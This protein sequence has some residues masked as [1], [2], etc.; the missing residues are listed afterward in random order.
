MSAQDSSFVRHAGLILFFLGFSFEFRVSVDASVNVGGVTPSRAPAASGDTSGFCCDSL[1][2]PSA[3]DVSYPGGGF[4]ALRSSLGI[5]S[6]PPF[7]I[8]PPCLVASYRSVSDEIAAGDGPKFFH[9]S[10]LDHSIWGTRET[11]S[12]RVSGVLHI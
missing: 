2:L 3:L 6:M 11:V 8:L 1:Y 7:P 10:K 5:R 12:G 4:G 9:Q